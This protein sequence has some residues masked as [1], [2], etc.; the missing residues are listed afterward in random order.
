MQKSETAKIFL[1]SI[2]ISSG[3]DLIFESSK[4]GVQDINLTKRAISIMKNFYFVLKQLQ[5]RLT[6]SSRP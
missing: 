2:N 5:N 1:W 3:P 6:F 4:K